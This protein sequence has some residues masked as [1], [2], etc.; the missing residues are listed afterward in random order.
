MK[1][2]LL[3]TFASVGAVL[4]M[5][6]LFSA[7][8]AHIINV[9]AQIENALYVHPQS[10]EFGTVFPQ[11]N[12][13]QGVFVTFSESFSAT[14]QTRVGNVDYKI[15]QKPEPRPE[16]ISQV[17]VDQARLWCEENLPQTPYD[18]NDTSWQD[19][20]ANCYPSLCPYLS[21]DPD[22]YP[23]PGNDV[24][25]PAF[26][27]P[28]A[29]SSIALGTINKFGTDVGDNWIIDLAVPCFEGSCAQDW[30]DFVHSKNPDVTDPAS[31]ELPAD[32]EHQIF[33]CDLWVE[34]TNIY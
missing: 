16:Y 34:V 15:V 18:A 4:V 9:T 25:V 17:G 12:L 8:E 13:A 22:N 33:G 26:H 31:Y 7:F 14:D 11:E 32:L 29:T 23:A 3:L 6:P 20:L 1:K 5:L 28:T 27:D 19:F 30:A 21:K 10:R 2:R 24:G